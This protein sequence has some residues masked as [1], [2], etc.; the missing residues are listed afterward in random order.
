MIN[1]RGVASF[2]REKKPKCF[3]ETFLKGINH[4]K[5]LNSFLKKQKNVPKM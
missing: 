2:S 4:I 1:I 3:K 5:P